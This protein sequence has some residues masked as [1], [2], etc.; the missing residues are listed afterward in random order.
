MNTID[1][2]EDLSVQ[3]D[4]VYIL[5][6]LLRLGVILQNYVQFCAWTV[7]RP[8]YVRSGLLHNSP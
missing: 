4:L 1:E 6:S 7:C 2:K 5:R 3:S 8:E